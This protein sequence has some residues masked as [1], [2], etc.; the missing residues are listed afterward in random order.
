MKKKCVKNY[1]KNK[2]AIHYDVA[3]LE[4][5]GSLDP[6]ILEEE[7]NEDNQFFESEDEIKYE[8]ESVLL[9]KKWLIQNNSPCL[10]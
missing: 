5:L 1:M 6:D 9:L 2:M 7:D 3:K 10:I 8:S 4:Y